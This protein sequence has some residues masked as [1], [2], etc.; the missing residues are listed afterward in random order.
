M[1]WKQRALYNLMSDISEECYCAGWMSQNE[2]TLWEMVV[3]PK[4]ERRY[5]MGTV[6]DEQIADLV[7]IS[8]EVG[9]WIRWRDDDDDK[10]LPAEDWGPVFTPMAEWLSMY[11]RQ[12]A[13]WARMREEMAARTAPGADGGA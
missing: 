2:Y 6:T 13:A 3:D 10:N 7:A 4:A 12:K 5:G 9:G 1:D 11:E 8:T